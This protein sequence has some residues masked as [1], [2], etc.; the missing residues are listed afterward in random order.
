MKK[1][2]RWYRLA[3]GGTLFFAATLVGEQAMAQVKEKRDFARERYCIIC[4][5]DFLY[6]VLD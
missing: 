2:N 6:G 3:M 5:Y 1:K 4:Q